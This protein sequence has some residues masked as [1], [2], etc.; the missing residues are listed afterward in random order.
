MNPLSLRLCNPPF[1]CCGSFPNIFTERFGKYEPSIE[2]GYKILDLNKLFQIIKFFAKDGVLKSYLHSLETASLMKA[3]PTGNGRAQNP[4]HIPIPRMTNTVLKPG[5]FKV[6]ELFEGIKRGI[7]ALGSSGGIVEPINGN[8]VFNAGEAFL[9]E[10][11]EAT[12]PLKDVSL[13]G[14]ILEILPKIGIRSKWIAL[15]CEG[16]RGEAN[17]VTLAPNGQFAVSGS[18]DKTLRLWDLKTGLIKAIN[19]EDPEASESA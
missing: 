13:A 7:Y 17:C 11:G 2:S 16:H 4:R 15:T 3:K 5:P 6:K 12:I 1:T 10:D 9:I 14:N 19:P 8:F 18:H